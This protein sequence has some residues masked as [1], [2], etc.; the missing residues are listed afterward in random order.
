M[1]V[2]LPWPSTSVSELLPTTALSHNSLSITD[3]PEMKVKPVNTESGNERISDTAVYSEWLTCIAATVAH[4]RGNQTPLVSSRVV[5]LDRGK[6]TRAVIPTD[7]V[8]QAVYGT[9]SCATELHIHVAH[10]CSTHLD[11]NTC[12]AQCFQVVDVHLVGLR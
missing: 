12:N 3:T 5:E 1:T 10:A 6:V 8:Q 4:V 2:C 7:D 9:H 11:K